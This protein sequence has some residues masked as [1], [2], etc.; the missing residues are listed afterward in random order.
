MYVHVSLPAELA[1]L[2][3]SAPFAKPLTR[4][5]LSPDAADDAAATSVVLRML[6]ADPRFS[7]I[8]DSM[9]MSDLLQ[10]T[11][12]RPK[13]SVAGSHEIKFKPASTNPLPVLSTLRVAVVAAGAAFALG[14]AVA[15]AYL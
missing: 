12:P 8:P 1:S 6:R 3:A 4:M 7:V 15:R 5:F 10:P 2:V 11:S 14:L 13:R 9:F